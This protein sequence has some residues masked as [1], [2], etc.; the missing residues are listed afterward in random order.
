MRTFLHVTLL[1]SK[2]T[3]KYFNRLLM[4]GTVSIFRSVIRNKQVGCRM[5][6]KVRRVSYIVQF[7]KEEQR[8]EEQFRACDQ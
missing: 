6:G 8:N 2:E 4:E 7:M 3:Q 1:L 5:D